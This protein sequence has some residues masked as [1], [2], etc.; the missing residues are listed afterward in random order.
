MPATKKKRVY[1][2]DSIMRRIAEREQGV[3]LAGGEVIWQ[4]E[5]NVG[6]EFETNTGDVSA[7]FAIV[8]RGTEPNRHGNKVLIK[9]D[10]RG[11]GLRV[12]R[13][14]RN[15][16]VLV[17]HG[18]NPNFPF[19][20]ATAQKPDGGVALRLSKAKAVSTAYFDEHSQQSMDIF[21]MVHTRRLRMASI[22]FKPTKATLLKRRPQRLPEGVQDLTQYAAGLDFVESD[23]WEWSVVAVG[24]DPDALRQTYDSG[25]CD[26]EKLGQSAL[27]WLRSLGAE[28]QSTM[29]PGWLPPERQGDKQTP[30]ESMLIE[31]GVTLRG[32]R[33]DQFLSAVNGLL[34]EGSDP[35]EDA[36]DEPNGDATADE[37]DTGAGDAGEET[38]GVEETHIDAGVE[39]QNIPHAANGPGLTG[40]QLAE[41]FDGQRRS[42]ALDQLADALP[43]LIGNAVEQAIAPVRE[44]QRLLRDELARRLGRVS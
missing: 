41:A 24:A 36:G 39:T 30:A 25:K 23:L 14:K 2:H 15:P 26:G 4:V 19:P 8:T 43:G 17:E 38:G 34:D 5:Q 9:P 11:E 28:F 22:G 7:T 40:E 31:Y 18:L 27:N 13:F 44:E 42:A 1:H 35:G 20:I 3:I 32:G 33:A 21:R 10:E 16:V 12:E 37:P 29:F 6:E